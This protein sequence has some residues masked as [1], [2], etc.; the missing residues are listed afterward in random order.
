MEAC[1]SSGGRLPKNLGECRGRGQSA[2]KALAKSDSGY[3]RSKFGH[4][5]DDSDGDC[6]D[7]RAEVLIAQSCTEVRFAEDERCRVLTGRWISPFTGQ[8][9][10]NASDI[11]IDYGANTWSREKR[12]K[13]ANDPRNLWSVELSL[14]R[15]KGTL[16]PEDWIPPTRQC[17]Y[18][19]SFL[20]I[21][22]IYGLKPP[23]GQFRQQLAKY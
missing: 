8:V 15:Q 19:T 12:E 10:Q 18:V 9:I 13:F 1:L 21:V 16:G 3:D 14:N 6:Q 22:K 4:G 7:S 23:Q 20:R 2:S 11:D 5:W 17:Q